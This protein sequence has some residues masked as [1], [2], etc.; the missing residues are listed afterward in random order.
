MS[1]PN[2][3]PQYDPWIQNP[4]GGSPEQVA[5][6]EVQWAR[7]LVTRLATEALTEK[8]RAR[9]WGILFKSLTLLYLFALLWFAMGGGEWFEEMAAGG[10]HTA[11]VR[12]DGVIADGLDASAENVIAGLRAAF[13]DD[14]TAGVILRINSPGGSPVQA[15]RIYDA[16]MRLRTQHPDKPLYAVVEDVCASGGYYVA[17]AAQ[18]IYADQASIVGSIGV[19]AG[20][21]GF[22]EAMDKLGIERRLYTAGENKALLDP[23]S[24]EQPRQVKYFQGLL[25]E[26]H[27]Q[28]IDAVKRGRGDRLADND[29]L[30]SGLVWSGMRGVELGLVDGLGGTRYVAEDLIGAE[31]L[32]DYTRSRGWAERLLTQLGYGAGLALERYLRPQLY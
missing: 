22:V 8:R 32:V 31:R 7:A 18:Q 28:F 2:D 19:I 26:V 15:G 21:F 1:E 29:E 9:R 12:L 30:F 17:S 23:F 16:I 10:R 13:E 25:E 14:G 27:Q 11:V 4:R 3:P 6:G 20:G 5:A 24:P